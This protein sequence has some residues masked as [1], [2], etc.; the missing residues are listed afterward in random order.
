MHT[1]FHVMNFTSDCQLIHLPQS[2]EVTAQIL[3]VSKSYSPSLL[4]VFC[5][6]NI[7]AAILSLSGNALVFLTVVSFSELHI[8][9]NIGLASFALANVF[10]GILRN[11]LSAAVS[12]VVLQG[13]C[14]FSGFSYI[15]CIF[16]AHASIYSSLLNLTLVTIERYVGVMHPL[17]YY[18]ILPPE[19]IAKFVAA[20]WFASPLLS[21]PN[22]VNNAAE[23]SQNI[24]TFTFSV[25]LAITLYCNL[26][27]HRVSRRQRQR[28]MKQ[29]AAIRQIADANQHRFRGARTQ[30]LILVTLVICFVPVLVLRFLAKA[31]S[32]ATNS[33]ILTL[34]KPWAALLFGLYTCVSP[35]L[36]FFRSREL[37]KYSK[38]LLRRAFNSWLS[39]FVQTSLG[40]DICRKCDTISFN[41]ILSKTRAP[42]TRE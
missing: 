2:H 25:S 16:W 20:V 40:R 41:S 33:M 12:V 26:K 24:M 32:E 22:L 3:S 9:S 28:L 14:P 8:T 23:L 27:I 6:V 42:K 29:A 5:T 35:F 17:R 37:R 4:V 21:V 13:G 38:K 10:V 15:F 34:A 7:M 1:S 36:Y 30:F 39:T 18:V 31:S 19:R 11:S